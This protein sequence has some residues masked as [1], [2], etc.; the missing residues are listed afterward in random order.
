MPVN[1]EISCSVLHFEEN[2]KSCKNVASCDAGNMRPQGI[3]GVSVFAIL[4]LKSTRRYKH[5]AEDTSHGFLHHLNDGK[6]DFV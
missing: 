2:R 6:R 5:I 3:P 4:T 1:I